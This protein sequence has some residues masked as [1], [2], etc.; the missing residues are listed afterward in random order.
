VGLLAA[1]RAEAV[2]ISLVTATP[3]IGLGQNVYV[4]VIL[5]GLEEGEA[6]RAFDLDIAFDDLRLG[7]EAL[8]FDVFLGDPGGDATVAGGLPEAGLVD[9]AENS[10]LSGAALQGLQSSEFRLARIAL[11]GLAPGSANLAFAQV[12]LIGLAAAPLPV[13]EATGLSILVV[14]E[15]VAVAYLLLGIAGL[16]GL[17]ARGRGTRRGA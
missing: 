14:P 6:L 9:L 8:V 10:F 11:Y 17:G 16:A 4:D 1:G 12:E 15:P 7:Y 13:T 2:S 3:E 5:S